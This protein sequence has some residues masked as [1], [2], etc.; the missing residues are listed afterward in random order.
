MGVVLTGANS[1][2][3]KGLARIRELGGLTLIQDPAT[4]ES[5]QM[6]EAAISEVGRKNVLPLAE[7]GDYLAKL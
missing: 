3:S 2:G 1:D 6:P 5:P 4:A 7:I